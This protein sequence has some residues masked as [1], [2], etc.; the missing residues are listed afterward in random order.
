MRTRRGE[1]P[2]A[3]VG[4]HA[5]PPWR[6]ELHRDFERA[7][8]ET[9]LP[10]RANYEKANELLIK[11]RRQRRIHFVFVRSMPWLCS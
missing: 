8:A 5:Q 3:E 1:L 11:A 2:P 4:G 7:F 6:K 9:R 10:E